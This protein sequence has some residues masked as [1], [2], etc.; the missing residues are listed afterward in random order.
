MACPR[1]A[2]D[3]SL[4]VVASELSRVIEQAL[5]FALGFLSAGLIALVIAPAVWQRA[6]RLT[7]RR[8]EASQP[9]T[10]AEIKAD[11][12]VLRAEFAVTARRLELNIA[13]LRHRNANQQIEVDRIRVKLRN[14]EA[15][16]A[17]QL[18][19]IARRDANVNANAE[20]TQ[21]LRDELEATR[22]TLAQRL[23][24]ISGLE[25]RIAELNTEIDERKLEISA[26]KGRL[27]TAGWQMDA[28]AGEKRAQETKLQALESEVERRSAAVAL[29]RD[30]ADRL[31]AELAAARSNLRPLDPSA[32]AGIPHDD[33]ERPEI[34]RLSAENLALEAKIRALTQDRDQLADS[35]ARAKARELGAPA[36][37]NDI[38]LLRD[39]L[40]DVA[41]RIAALAAVTD[42]P[43][44]TVDSILAAAPEG[45]EP[46][47]L[48]D[49]VGAPPA[50]LANGT[51]HDHDD[52]ERTVI[53]PRIDRK[54]LSL[55]E[56][57]QALRR[58]TA[59][60]DEPL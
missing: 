52:G 17:A 21:T 10:L 60:S 41:A 23:E 35:A 32:S 55:A 1:P 7:R 49:G 16:H 38:A 33:N 56:R 14:A 12:D 13:N 30:R 36:D 54:P 57:I 22:A 40:G 8:I 42:S 24:L 5:Y 28:L 11:R 2:K 4:G 9:L 47:N 51:G 58:A 50:S 26:M 29:E 59:G 19:E 34:Q 45:A 31:T 53:L 20:L 44:S 6:V 27:E 37:A 18:A 48:P 3:K 43:R 46:A 25:A 39:R 15:E